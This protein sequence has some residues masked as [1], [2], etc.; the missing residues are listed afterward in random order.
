MRILNTTIFLLIAHLLLG[1]S[2]PKSIEAE[3][4]RT[5]DGKKR[6]NLT[7][8]LARAYMNSDAAKAGTY[9]QQC[10]QMAVEQGDRELII[11]ASALGAQAAIKKGDYDLGVQR[12]QRAWR[13]ARD[14][15]NITSASQ[16]Y[17]LLRN[18]LDKRGRHRE[19]AQLGKE[20]VE[21]LKKS[22]GVSSPQTTI[23]MVPESSIKGSG[24]D[25]ADEYISEIAQLKSRIVDLNKEL[26]RNRGQSQSVEKLQDDVENAEKFA[27]KSLSEKEQ[28]L[29]VMS[30]EKV[31]A[32]QLVAKRQKILEALKDESKLKE[33]L[34]EQ[35]KNE[36]AAAQLSL[37]RSQNFRNLSFIGI[38]IALFLAFVFWL[39]FREKLKGQRV[40]ETKNKTIEKEKERSEDLLLNILPAPI[41]LEL[42]ENGKAIARKYENASVLFADFQNFTKIAENLSPEDLV[43]DLDYCFKGFDFIISQYGIEKIKTI[44]DAYMCASGLSDRI[45]YP[46]QIIK[47]ALEMQQFLEDV[48]A[49]RIQK[50]LPFFEARIGINTGPVVAG[51]VGVK[52]FAYDIWGD[53]VNI[54]SRIQ[55]AGVPGR[56]NISE[57]TYNQVKYDFNCFYRGKI[58]VKNKGEFDM[59]YVE[60][61]S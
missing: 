28:E 45:S 57:S 52:K 55:T 5:Q 27:Q 10:Y 4:S 39:R 50:G 24:S 20:M 47:A 37:E 19:S 53:T 40:L 35:Q 60:N 43:K 29:E 2:S 22:N 21:L 56:V 6:M 15:S 13:H 17:D 41:A 30:K 16:L 31:K 25:N 58:A 26:L 7:Y 38:G 42:K 59:Y 32:E 46:T 33:M 14:F 12:F 3:L 23:S 18:L 51:V 49:D 11:N 34:V 36:L 54:A 9:A 44:G 8:D 48:K 61:L 1:Q